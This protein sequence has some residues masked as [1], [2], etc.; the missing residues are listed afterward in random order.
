[1]RRFRPIFLALFFSAL[2]SR[3]FAQDTYRIVHTYPHDPESFTQ[4][5]VF[6]DG[7]L[8]ESTGLN[9]RSSLRMDD[10]E[11]GHALQK[12][13]IDPKYFAE[14]LTNWGS[15]LVQLTWKANTAFVYD[16]F[17]FRQLKTFHYDGEGWGLTQDGHSLILS[18]GTA[19]LRFL[20]PE[21]FAVR[22]RITVSDHGI[23]V[24]E[25]NELEYIHGEI[26]ANI[27][28]QKRIAR[29]SPATGKVLSW[30]DLSGLVAD[31]GVTDE[32]AVL[33]GIAYDAQHDRLFVT[34]KLW[35]K[36]Y[37]IKIVKQP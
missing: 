8:Y 15:T 3:A 13:D 34:G 17:S 32:N 11:T 1:M 10:L 33:N 37:E 2:L 18:D 5:L 31:A 20:N 30:I 4:G 36:L 14:G 23:P 16:R 27:W 28:F 9:G 21:T 24:K 6:V 19:T 25:L 22:R 7:H 12:L 29:I 35:P 26:Y